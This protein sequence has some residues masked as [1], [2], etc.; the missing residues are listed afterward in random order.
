MGSKL[1]LRLALIIT[2]LSCPAF[3]G[4]IPT[5]SV[6]ELTQM[7]KNAQQQARESLAQLEKAKESILQAKNQYEHYKSIMQGNNKLG[8]FLNDPKIKQL[9]PMGDW[10]DIY[11]RAQDLPS[12]RNRY[13]LTSQDPKVQAVFDKL[14]SQAGT[15]EAQYKATNKRIETAEGL[16]RQLNRV[17]TPKDREQLALRY[18]QEMLEMQAQQMQLQN[19]RYLVEQKEKMEKERI[20]QEILNFFM[21]KTDK[22]PQTD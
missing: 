7:V 8:D 5:V 20:N 9:L 14:L 21:G 17:E 22:F 18:Q 1:T 11:Q 4:G 10:M 3:S 12:L 13:G 6:A 16:R 15:L 19:A 2:C